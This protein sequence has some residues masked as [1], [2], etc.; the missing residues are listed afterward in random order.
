MLQDSG[1]RGLLAC[2]CRQPAGN[3]Q[4]RTRID[5]AFQIVS[6]SCRDLQAGSLRSP[7]I[8]CGVDSLSRN[9]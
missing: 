1:E 4:M 7:E 3:I 9:R 6:A 8:F 5:R 2:S